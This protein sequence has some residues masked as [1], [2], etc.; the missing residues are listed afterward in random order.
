MT[1]WRHRTRIVIISRQFQ[2]SVQSIFE[3]WRNPKRG[4]LYARTRKAPAVQEISRNVLTITG[5]DLTETVFRNQRQFL[6]FTEEE[7]RTGDFRDFSTYICALS[8]LSRPLPEYLFTE[9]IGNL[10]TFSNVSNA[11]NALEQVLPTHLT[12]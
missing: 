3:S 12:H 10:P 2:I 11:L 4:T 6:Y 9:A 1:S 7:L 8:R 5:S